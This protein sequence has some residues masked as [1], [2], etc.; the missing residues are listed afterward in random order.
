MI[1]KKIQL[2]LVI[3]FLALS[4]F[5]STLRIISL[6]P[7]ETRQLYV[8]GVGEQIVGDTT[9]CIYPE[10]ARFK[11]KVGSVLNINVEK[12]ISLKPDIIFANGLNNT[13]QLDAL[14]KYGINNIVIF[15]EPKSYREICQQFL[16]MGKKV[17]KAKEASEMIAKSK[18]A[19]ADIELSLIKV[20]KVKVFIQIGSEPLF[21]V[22][23]DTFINDMITSAGGLNIAESSSNGVYSIEKVLE[24]RP[25]VII[26]S[27][28][29]NEEGKAVNMWSKFQDIPAVKN[30]R[31]YTISAVELCSPN[32]VTY[33]DTLMKIV[34][35]LHPER[36][37]N[38]G[39]E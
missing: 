30:K 27:L 18:K 21:T 13:K 5:A 31:I 25:N 8:L 6:G 29:G 24:Y 3:F 10:A 1:L 35:M 14:K 12:I 9:F 38:K 22:L 19:V 34:K 11:E 15:N 33:P 36:V 4:C 32:P 16:D 7:S 23:K 37:S 28:M 39:S 2:A 26:I 17:G 20:K